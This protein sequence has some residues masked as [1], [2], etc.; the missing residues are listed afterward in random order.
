MHN[1]DQSK[2][3]V[4][5]VVQ[6]Y[7]ENGDVTVRS[8]FISFFIFFTQWSLF[9]SFFVF[10]YFTIYLSN[11]MLY[12]VHSVASPLVTSREASSVLM[13]RAATAV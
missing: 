10:F 1:V 11:N 3:M 7:G 4:F 6:F 2:S 8:A 12:N 9:F 5:D 13:L